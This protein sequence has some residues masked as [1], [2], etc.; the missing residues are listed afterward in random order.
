MLVAAL[1]LAG[2]ASR[3]TAGAGWDVRAV[4]VRWRRPVGG[5]RGMGGSCCGHSR[6]GSRSPGAGPGNLT[7]LLRTAREE[8]ARAGWSVAVRL[9]ARVVAL[10]PL[11]DG[12]VRS[13]TRC[14]ISLQRRA[15]VA[16]CSLA[17]VGAL[18][19]CT[20]SSVLAVVVVLLSRCH[21]GRSA[22]DRTMERARH[23][24]GRARGASPSVTW[25]ASSIPSRRVRRGAAS[26]A[27]AVAG[28][29][30]VDDRGRSRRSPLVAGRRER[31]PRARRP[32]RPGPDASGLSTYVPMPVVV[33]GLAVAALVTPASG[34][35]SPSGW[36]G[37]PDRA[38]RSRTISRQVAAADVPAG[39]C[40]T[41]RPVDRR[42]VHGPILERLVP[43]RSADRRR[44]GAGR[45]GGPPAT[46]V[47]RR[48]RLADAPACWRRGPDVPGIGRFGA[49]RAHLEHSRPRPS[50]RS[51]RGAIDVRTRARH[52]ARARGRRGVAGRGARTW[53]PQFDDVAARTELVTSG[54]L[55]EV[56]AV[57]GARAPG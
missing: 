36:R 3:S 42:A 10:P 51:S 25:S 31:R 50:R 29:G 6:S 20:L 7:A 26:A 14:R 46:R 21:R 45:A 8:Q 24:G 47:R 17:V 22:G 1:A 37:R 23:C 11:V 32:R 41:T 30:A 35:T 5:R 27:L 9:V 54:R 33:A 12:G 34:T 39:R 4:L 15:P 52:R 38:S 53:R 56:R 28:L 18:G 44:R 48:W 57:H 40:S 19:R 43:R 55:A 16:G 49:H 2:V 13:P